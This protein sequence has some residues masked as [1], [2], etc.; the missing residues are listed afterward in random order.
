VVFDEASQVRVADAVGAMGRGR[1]VVVVGDSK[2][3][4]PTSFAESAFAGDDIEPDSTGDTVEDEESILTECVQARVKRHRLTW[5][6]RSQ[7]ESLIAFS[8]Q[9]YY[10]GKLSSF[11][12]PAVGNAAVSLVQVGGQFHRSG[13]GALLRTNPIE[14]EAVVAEVR[15]R[16]DAS[17]AALPSIGVVTFNLQQ[18]AH[19]EGL[20]RDVEDSRIVEALDDSEGLFV[21][22]L[23][24]VQGDERDVILFSTAF[25]ANQKGVLP[26]NFGPLNRVGGER[27]LN[28]AVTRAR[29]QIMVFS[30]FEPS[31][32]RTE[33]TSSIGVKH[34]RTY[35]DM[36]AHGPSVLPGDPR[37]RTTPDRH[38][39][40]IALELQKRGLTVRTN[41]GLSD[42]T[43]DLVLADPSAPDQP[44]VAV[45]LDGPTWANRLTARD[46]DALPQEVLAGVLGWPAVERVW[47][48]TWLADPDEVVDRLVDA[49]QGA[50]RNASSEGTEVQPTLSP[51][52]PDGCETDSSDLQ[53]AEPDLLE[54]DLIRS[55][56]S[57]PMTIDSPSRSSHQPTSGYEQ[58]YAPKSSEPNQAFRTAPAAPAPANGD[59]A[60]S[61]RAE[62]FVPWTVRPL[63][64]VDVLDSLP[65]RWAAERVTAAILEVVTA[66]GPIHTERLARLVANSF[67][68]NRVVGSR[69][70]AILAHLPQTLRTDSAEPV[71]WPTERNPDH[72]TG[73]R[74]SASEKNDRPIE[75][76]ALREIGNAMV[77]SVKE[78]AGFHRDELHREVLQVFGMRRR[79]ASVLE[80][81]DTALELAIRSRRLQT[82]PDGLIIARS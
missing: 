21:K 78:A 60:W 62:V 35:L 19:I 16:F 37:R 40:Q 45:L 70:S 58:L 24:N 39:D 63:G 26:L 1:S 6:Y 75:H 17:P 69:K 12:A 67:G 54:S 57:P 77:A 64:A 4:P 20:L 15:R 41:V 30:S 74:R 53:P 38:R 28:V 2:Q 7:D 66:E 33:D 22:N 48:P 42:F 65:F 52:T 18:R 76:I 10:E 13:K 71:I 61:P 9:H 55:Q 23:E 31:D 46:R 25:S 59:I 29:R 80:R 68:L 47:L 34:L 79:T 82:E 3:M 14:A 49:V 27:R 5:H 32:M 36:A 11:P 56:S 8:N 50:H 72:W 81:L 43:L 73:F 44:L 51:E